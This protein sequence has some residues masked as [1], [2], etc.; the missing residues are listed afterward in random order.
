M[1]TF[2][3]SFIRLFYPFSIRLLSFCDP[4][5]LFLSFLGFQLRISR[6][7]GEIGLGWKDY[8]WF[9]SLI[10]LPPLP[11]PSLPHP[12]IP[13]KPKKE[14]YQFIIHSLDIQRRTDRQTDRH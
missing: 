7:E 4:I 2:K 1:L 13:C 9:P 3:E 11:P 14:D 6:R 12:N 10:Y 5:I 8:H